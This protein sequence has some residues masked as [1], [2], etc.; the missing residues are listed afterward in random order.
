MTGERVSLIYDHSDNPLR[1]GITLLALS[2]D[3]MVAFAHSGGIVDVY[4]LDVTS[5]SSIKLGALKFQTKLR[6]VTQIQFISATRILVVWMRGEQLRMYS[7]DGT[8][9]GEL[10]ASEGAYSV[11]DHEAQGQRSRILLIE[12]QTLRQ[13]DAEE[14]PARVGEVDIRLDYSMATTSDSMGPIKSAAI[15][16]YTLVLDVKFSGSKDTWLFLFDLKKVREAR[17]QDVCLAPLPLTSRLAPMVRRIVATR[18]DGAPGDQLL[19]L[20]KDNWIFGVS[21][22][23]QSAETYGLYFPVQNEVFVDGVGAGGSL[24][25]LRTIDDDIIFNSRGKFVVFK[26]GLKYP[27]VKKL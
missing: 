12:G 4:D 11:V 1:G 6:S 20:S 9:K 16:G 3:N 10:K 26:N 13:Y 15:Y 24:L 19:F 17:T 5:S 14:F 8:C 7:L 22:E 18:P 2:M 27:D 21:L 23:D 25:P